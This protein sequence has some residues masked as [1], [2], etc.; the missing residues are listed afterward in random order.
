V[1]GCAGWGCC[2]V[3]AGAVCCWEVLKALGG[4]CV[5]QRGTDRDCVL[6]QE[7]WGSSGQHRGDSERKQEAAG[8]KNHFFKF[9]WVL[10]S[11]SSISEVKDRLILMYTD[12]NTGG[13]AAVGWGCRLCRGEFL[14]MA[15]KRQGNG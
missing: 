8:R 9:T 2:A 14:V 4:G 15:G 3:G 1:S 7:R 12:E 10:S 6:R 13:K 11:R 5:G